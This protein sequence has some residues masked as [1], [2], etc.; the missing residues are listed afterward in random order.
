MKEESL[1]ANKIW[2]DSK[3]EQLPMSRDHMSFA[4]QNV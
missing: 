2:I 1:N 4:L 3:V